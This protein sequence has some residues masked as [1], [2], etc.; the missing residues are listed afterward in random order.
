MARARSTDA[1]DAVTCF[2]A[3]A[4]YQKRDPPPAPV[5][6]RRVAAEPLPVV[7]P[8]PIPALDLE[9]RGRA[10]IRGRKLIGT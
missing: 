10:I 8:E 6:P 4:N 9:P 2:L 5:R 1:A 3:Y 7:T